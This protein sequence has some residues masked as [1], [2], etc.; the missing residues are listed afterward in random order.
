MI[1]C[2]G[3]GDLDVIVTSLVIYASETVETFED[4]WE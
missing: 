4:H 2:D 3:S 1:T